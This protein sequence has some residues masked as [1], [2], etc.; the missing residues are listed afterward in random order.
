[1][2][3]YDV[4][5]Q[6]LNGLELAENKLFASTGMDGGS[7][8]IASLHR[9]NLLEQ[10]RSSCREANFCRPIAETCWFRLILKILLKYFY[11]RR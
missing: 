6:R 1:M 11:L 9:C 10:R 3:E 4:H 7:A 8:E 2:R 5:L